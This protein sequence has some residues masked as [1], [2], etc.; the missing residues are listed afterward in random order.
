MNR[1]VPAGGSQGT[2]CCHG[3][4][5]TTCCGLARACRKMAPGTPKDTDAVCGVHGAYRERQHRRTRVVR[6]SSHHQLP[7]GGRFAK[8]CYTRTPLW[9]HVMYRNLRAE[10]GAAPGHFDIHCRGTVPPDHG[11][12][13]HGISFLYV[14]PVRTVRLGLPGPG[15]PRRT[16]TGLRGSRRNR[17]T[18]AGPRPQPRPCGA[19]IPY[20]LAA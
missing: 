17:P 19:V 7:E 10:R 13:G 12:G 8:K 2:E 4:R 20:G 1:Q 14:E 9:Y 5:H 18:K 16:V 3:G 11:V 6:D 15:C